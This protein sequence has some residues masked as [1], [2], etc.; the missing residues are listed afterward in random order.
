[1]TAYAVSTDSIITTDGSAF[2][3]SGFGGAGFADGFS[4]IVYD[5][6]LV[7]SDVSTVI[8]SYLLRVNENQT[9]TDTA[10]SNVIFS[11]YLI[12]P[13]AQTEVSTASQDFPVA[14][15][16]ES[17]TL[18]DIS[19][20][21]QGYNVS[22]A[23]ESQTLTD[24]S[25]SS[26]DFAV[27]SSNESQ[28]LSETETIQTAFVGRV[29]ELQTLTD[30]ETVQADLL[31]SQSETVTLTDTNVGSNAISVTTNSTS[32]TNGS[33]FAAASFGEVGFADGYSTIVYSN[34][35]T[36]ND[37]E[38]VQVSFIG[39][40]EEGQTLVSQEDVT[41]YFL[42]VSSYNDQ[43]LTD[44]NV[45]V[46]GV[47]ASIDGG[48]QTITDAYNGGFFLAAVQTET[49][50]IS[51][52]E[53]VLVAFTGNIDEVQTITTVQTALAAF[54]A[55]QVET[56]TLLDYQ[57]ARGWFK[58]NDNQSVTWVPINTNGDSIVQ[59]TNNALQ[60]DIW[61]NDLGYILFWSSTGGHS[62]TWQLVNNTQ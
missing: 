15:S 39:D 6:T 42:V 19:I 60:N 53:N 51:D 32:N 18:T 44:I 28:T 24:S 49:T 14:G 30:T 62:P 20:G 40:I 54:L 43:A 55:S 33:A 46:R 10:S 5:N 16:N 45:V 1:M 27:F 61:S 37:T 34:T 52:S 59:W 12:E 21:S 48:T 13:Q 4:T 31:F 35:L 11:F 3:S 22:S 38:S 25:A 7:T 26:Q 50:T 56:T 58:I 36:Q 29:N 41:A 9:L 8:S 47:Y 57:Y 2:A 23:N 17:Q